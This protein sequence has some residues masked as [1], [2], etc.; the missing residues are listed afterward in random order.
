[1]P[2]RQ[3]TFDL[4]PTTLVN[5]NGPTRAM[6]SKQAK[7]AHRQRNAGPKISRAEQ[8]RLDKQ[9]IDRQNKEYERE[10]TA[11]RAKVA[12]ERKAEKAQAQKE[13][14]KRRGLP[15][16]SKFVRASQPMISGFVKRVSKR[17][18][19][20]METVEEEEEESDGTVF[21]QYDAEP[22][23]KRRLYDESEDDFGEFPSLS[24]SFLPMLDNIGPSTSKKDEVKKYEGSVEG[25]GEDADY[26][27]AKGAI[28]IDQ[29]QQSE[30]ELAV[31]DMV[32]IQLLLEAAEAA[33]RAADTL[34]RPA[35]KELSANIRL[36]AP[37]A[38]IAKSITFAPTP[39]RPRK[40]PV[41]TAMHEFLPS[42]TQLYIENNLD[43]FL[44]SPSQELREL[45]GDIDDDDL[46][47]NTQ[48]AKELNSIEA[49][50]EDAFVNICT[51][52]LIMSSQELLELV[53]PS[54]PPQ[55]AGSTKPLLQPT[56]PKPKRLF[57]EEK[58]E[59]LVHAAIHESKTEVLLKK[60]VVPS[61]GSSVQPSRS[62]RRVPSTVTDYG[63]DEI[64]DEDLLGLVD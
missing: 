35:M 48:I 61:K 59:D 3:Q 47:S 38:N 14:R 58:E 55:H 50:H 57:F 2:G 40:A 33:T 29:S 8:A 16:P 6:T 54:R 45:L 23:S 19:E 44:P 17:S 41:M 43:D 22:P 18:R 7:K 53:T 31:A 56:L 60:Q 42:A 30:D 51:Q 10:R 52:D 21:E 27:S 34:S 24:Q 13:E 5:Y 12:R 9:E 26:I 15:E 62:L 49:I 28:A 36:P 37:P 32:A 20:A 63:E 25:L 39:P 46:P 11:A 64:D 4:V 1:M